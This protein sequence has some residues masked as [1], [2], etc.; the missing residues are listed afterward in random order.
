MTATVVLRPMSGASFDAYAVRAI[1]LLAEAQSRAYGSSAQAARASAEAAFLKIC[2]DAEPEASGQ[3]LYAI[4]AAG[5]DVGALWFE[6]RQA[7]LDPYVYLYDWVIWPEY[8][9]Q[10]LGSAAMR[11]LEQRARALGARRI[12]LNVFNDNRFA[13]DLYRRYGFAPAS[14]ILVKPIPND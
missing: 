2:A 14:S 5:A 10:G 13:A 11:L 12:M 9:G 3:H 7:A 1:P 6:L 8:R 4:E